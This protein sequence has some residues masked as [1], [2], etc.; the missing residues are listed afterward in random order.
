M[1]N[2]ARNAYYSAPE[3]AECCLEL[4][5]LLAQSNTGEDYTEPE[6]YGGF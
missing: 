3:A 4:M 2:T 1:Q 5:F 6:E